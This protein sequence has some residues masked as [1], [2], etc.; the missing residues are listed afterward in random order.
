VSQ[1]EQLISQT[2]RAQLS[3]A[4][5]ISIQEGDAVGTTSGAVELAATPESLTQSEARVADLE[6]LTQVQPL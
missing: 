2:L 4:E 6:A 3:V 1:E 5:K